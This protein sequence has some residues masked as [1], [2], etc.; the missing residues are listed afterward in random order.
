MDTRID[1]K[2]SPVMFNR[3]PTVRIG[4]GNDLHDI[5]L[6]KPT[7]FHWS[8][9]QLQDTSI[10]LTVEQYGKTNKDTIPEQQLDTAIVIEE[11][12]LNGLT[13]PKFAWAG[14]YRPEYPA[15]YPNKIPELTNLNY[16]G[17]NGVW[18]LKLTVPIYTWIHKIENLGWI[19]D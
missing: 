8:I 4:I 9:D 14:V 16:L 12:K 7:W 3:A 10:I 1:I 11:V 19:Y 17:W 5:I 15:H 13:S 18:T 6:T 2:L